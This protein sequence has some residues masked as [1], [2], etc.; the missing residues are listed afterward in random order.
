[1]EM[2]QSYKNET[3]KLLEVLLKLKNYEMSIEKL[4][5]HVEALEFAND[6]ETTKQDEPSPAIV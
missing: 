6:K 4:Q 5:T 3:E 2:F 1:M